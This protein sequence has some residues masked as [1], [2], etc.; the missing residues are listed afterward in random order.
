MHFFVSLCSVLR[1]CSPHSLFYFH[2]EMW[3]K[4]HFPIANKINFNIF[5]G[6]A[7]DRFHL[8]QQTAA[9]KYHYM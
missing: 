7:A 2:Y 5:G 4:K 3:N 8:N 1:V 9:T 6:A